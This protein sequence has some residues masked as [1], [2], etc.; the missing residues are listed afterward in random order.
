MV[1]L[2]LLEEPRGFKVEFIRMSLSTILS[3]LHFVWAT[4]F[5]MKDKFMF[6]IFICTSVVAK[7]FLAR[8][9]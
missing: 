7:Q 5:T 2:F 3:I 6:F 8:K 4:V 9:R 1:T